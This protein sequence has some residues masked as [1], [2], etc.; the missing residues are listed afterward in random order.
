VI[1][2]DVM[3]DFCGGLDD[4]AEDDVVAIDEVPEDD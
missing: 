2:L 3:A 4:A 1:S